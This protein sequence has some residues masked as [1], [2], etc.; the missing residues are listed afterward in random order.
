MNSPTNAFG[1][2]EAQ[3]LSGRDAAGEMSIPQ[4]GFGCAHSNMF[5]F[6]RAGSRSRPGTPTPLVYHHNP[7]W[8]AHAD[9]AARRIFEALGHD[10]R[11]SECAERPHHLDDPDKGVSLDRC[12][13]KP[14]STMRSDRALF[15]R[16]ETNLAPA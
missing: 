10:A 11:K 1:A 15:G 4:C 2:C 12:G 3:G 9:D 13:S 16:A 14:G 5:N 7:S 8:Y 6:G